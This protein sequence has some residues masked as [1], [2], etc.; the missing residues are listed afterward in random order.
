VRPGKRGREGG[1]ERWA[2]FMGF[3]EGAEGRGEFFWKKRVPL[4]LLL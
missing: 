2:V 3:E 1:K 4:F